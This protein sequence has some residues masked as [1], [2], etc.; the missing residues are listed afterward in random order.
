M[1]TL[2]ETI[3]VSFSYP[4]SQTKALNKLKLRIPEGKKTAICGHNGSGKSTLF[5][6]AIGIHTPSSGQVLWKNKPLTYERKE[7]KQLRQD[8]GL[9]FQDPEQQLILNTPYEDVTY[10]LRNAAVP[11]PEITRR[12]EAILLTLGLEHLAHTPI[13]HLSLGQKKRVALAGV[14]VLEPKLLLLDEPTAYLDRISEQQLV[15]ELDRIH[16]RGITLVMATHDMNLAYSWADWILVMDRGQ[17]V[18]EGTPAEIFKD[19]KALN[20]L[21]LDRPMLLDLWDAL[22]EASRQGVSAPR[23]VS[24]FTTLLQKVFA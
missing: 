19:S 16:S 21:G 20:S 3:E 24:D 9:V 7:L 15:E 4:A 17:C 23:N 14:L 5:L 12:A 8:V 1:S 18:M 10:G 2:L 13:H 22:P 6:Q 11:E